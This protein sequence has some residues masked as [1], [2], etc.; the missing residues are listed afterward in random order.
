MIGLRFTSWHH[1]LCAI[2]ALVTSAALNA[3]EVSC[4]D[5]AIDA[6]A[7]LESGVEARGIQSTQCDS[8]SL[9]LAVAKQMLAGENDSFELHALQPASQEE[10]SARTLRLAGARQTPDRRMV[11]VD[12]HV[13]NGRERPSVE[14]HWY[15]LE[16]FG[17]Y[18]VTNRPIEAGEVIRPDD[19]QRLR[20]AVDYADRPTWETW[21]AAIRAQIRLGD[22][23]MLR[24]THVSR[25]PDIV[26]GDR[27]V[28]ELQR[29]PIKLQL[30]ADVQEAAFI[31]K[32][33]KLKLRHSGAIVYGRLQANNIVV[34]CDS[35]LLHGRNVCND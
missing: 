12:W 30:D 15:A 33:V 4:A 26:A 35:R 24:A 16:R 6:L 28:L 23:H 19:V 31:D 22:G 17:W 25:I 2:C 20:G 14:V 34:P 1:S 9:S 10:N 8:A 5:V 3:A 13:Q 18:W 21:P 32:T 27:A 11:R 29:G 7:N